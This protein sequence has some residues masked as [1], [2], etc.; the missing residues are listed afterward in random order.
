MRDEDR[1]RSVHMIEAAEAARAFVSGRERADLDTDLMLL[2]AISKALEVFGEAAANVSV[3]TRASSASVPWA[4][5]IGMRNRLIHAC[6]SINRNIVWRTAT[7][8][9][10]AFLPLLRQLVKE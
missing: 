6:S 10:P 8:E 7:E 5:I 9:I 1:T 2:F 4:Q 3:E